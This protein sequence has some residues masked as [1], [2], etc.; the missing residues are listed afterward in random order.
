MR[1]RKVGHPL[2]I[3]DET[4]NKGIDYIRKTK[5]I[6]EVVISGG[7]PLL[8]EDN[9]LGNILK[10]LRAIGHIEILRIHTRIPCTLP[11][12]ITKDL[13]DMLR[14]HHPLFINVHFNH[15]DE[16]TK[17]ADLACATLA[18]AGIPLGCQTVLLNGINNS[19]DIMKALMKRL[20]MIRVKPYYI[21]QLDTVKGNLHFNTTIEEGLYIM[22]SLYGL[23]GL[24]VPQYMKDLPGGGGKVPM[25]PEYFK[26]V[27]GDTLKLAQY[28]DSSIVD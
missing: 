10:D 17:E 16:I 24:C 11:Q 3:T 15:P 28:K 26:T 19:P 4:I 22:Q 18:D 7:D 13:A 12:R 1:K 27:S 8:L 25:L 5:H 14:C 21:H 2:S 20:V 23:S 9:K 6:R